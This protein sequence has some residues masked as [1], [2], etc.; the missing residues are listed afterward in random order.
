MAKKKK[1]RNVMIKNLLNGVK[2]KFSEKG[3]LSPQQ[4]GNNLKRQATN[5]LADL[6]A[7]S[8]ETVFIEDGNLLIGVD[9][10]DKEVFVRVA[11]VVQTQK[12]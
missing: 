11:V 3:K 9:A 10:D 7:E 1:E 8:G 5:Y 6:L 12:E 2:I 4:V